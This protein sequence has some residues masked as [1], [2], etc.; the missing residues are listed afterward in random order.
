[1]HK[2]LGLKS[3]TVGGLLDRQF[4]PRTVILDPW[5]RDEETCVVWAATGVGK[6]MFSL[7]IAVA[8]AGGGKLG[9]WDAPEARKVTYID[10]EMNVRDL[11]ERLSQMV[12]E[13]DLLSGKAQVELARQNMTIIARQDQLEASEFLDITNPEHQQKLVKSIKGNCDLLIL[14]NFTT[15]STG[16]A[17]ENDATAFKQVQELFMKLK[18]AKI[19]AILVHHSNK[20]GGN[21]RGSTALEATFE[22]IL[23]LKRPKVSAAGEARFRAEFTKFRSKGDE[24]QT[25]R[26]WTLT[27]D[28]WDVT[29]DVMDDPKEDRVYLALKSLNYTSLQAIADALKMSKS[30][31]HRRVQ[32]L[33]AMGT[34][35]RRERNECFGKAKDL[36]YPDGHTPFDEFIE[37]EY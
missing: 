18:K 9:D 27:K 6:T 12:N 8:V 1:M 3:E 20:T 28:G 2:L 16:L 32:R 35:S 21:M 30:A 10:G 31:V 36:K 7:S 17:D 19:S 15:L 33:E 22:I 4:E 29:D 24:S 11:Q 34:L 5:L 25:S 14:D 37:E 13:M 26:T 23:A